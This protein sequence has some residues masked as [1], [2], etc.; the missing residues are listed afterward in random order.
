VSI[1]VRVLA[2]SVFELSGV[3]NVF[4]MRWVALRSMLPPLP[5]PPLRPLPPRIDGSLNGGKRRG[6]SE[7]RLKGTLNGSGIFMICEMPGKLVRDNP[8][9]MGDRL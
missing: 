8:E 4:L 3:S 2:L 1:E 9:N 7:D 6:G 5:P